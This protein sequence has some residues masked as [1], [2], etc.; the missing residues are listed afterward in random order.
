MHATHAMHHPRCGPPE[1]WLGWLAMT[2]RREQGPRH[3]RHGGPWHGSGPFGRGMGPWGRGGPRA[4]R[5]DVR[6]ALLFLLD[7]EPRNGYQLMQ[8]I[9]ERSNGVWRPSPGSVYPALQQLEDEDLVR[10][11]ERDGRRAFALT[12]AG[13]AHVSE[14]RADIETLWEEL[15][16]AVPEGLTDVR[17]LVAQVAAAAMHATRAGDDAQAEQVRD[18][19]VEARRSIYRILAEE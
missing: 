3:G 5:G 19:L 7:E 2:G 4:R 17:S 8:A 18:V 15:R 12:D 6:S 13:R 1:Q 10:G 14:H 9:E 16:G 11:E